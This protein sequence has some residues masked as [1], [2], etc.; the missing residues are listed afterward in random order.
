MKLLSAY[1]LLA[2]LA[3]A[4]TTHDA[5]AVLQ[6][7]AKH[8][9]TMLSRLAKEGMITRLAQG[10]WAYAHDLDPLLLPS[11]LSYPM[12]SYVSLYTALYFHGM[13]E[14]I[15]ETLYAISLCKTKQF[16]TPLGHVSL[17]H[18]ASPLFTGYKAYGKNQVL[19]ANPEKALFDTLYLA[20][21]KSLRFTTLTELEL[22]EGFN[23]STF[24][25][26]LPLIKHLGRRSLVEA[27]LKSFLP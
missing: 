18:I 3:P 8:T 25:A 5:S 12:L 13:I 23:V 4:F 15:P 24:Q 22:P 19:M 7:N 1:K 21:A 11:L 16:S 26:W 27:K 9:S 17:H 6:A 20:P 10:R 14:Q 2:S